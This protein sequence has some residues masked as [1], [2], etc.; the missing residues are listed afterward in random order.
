M[1]FMFTPKQIE[2]IRQALG[3]TVA[4][5]A[6]R[7]GVDRNAVY[8]WESGQRHPRYETLLTLNRLAKAAGLAVA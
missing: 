2:E 4:E 3:L 5:F 1:L 7:L 8:L 6:E